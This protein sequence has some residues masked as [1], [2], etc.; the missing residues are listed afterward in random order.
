MVD[1][2]R[3]FWSK[4]SEGI[5]RDS[6]EMHHGIEPFEH[7]G[8]DVTYVGRDACD[9]GRFG[10]QRATIEEEAV[11]TDDLVARGLEMGDECTSDVAVMAGYENAHRHSQTFHGA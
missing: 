2:E 10:P 6:G 3:R 4:I 5:V 1:V 11:E 8:T 7:A 9:P